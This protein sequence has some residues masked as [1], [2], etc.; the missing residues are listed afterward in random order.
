MIEISLASLICGIIAVLFSGFSLGMSVSNL[1]NRETKNAVADE[2]IDRVKKEIPQNNS[3][4]ISAEKV[5]A[6]ISKAI[7][8][9]ANHDIRGEEK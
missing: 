4:S 6:K 2:I 5:S 3:D 1:L 8:D 9:L 7:S